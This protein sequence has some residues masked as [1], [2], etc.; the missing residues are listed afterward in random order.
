M[1][2]L[3]STGLTQSY[4]LYRPLTGSFTAGTWYDLD[5][6]RTT[7][8]SGIY[9]IKAFVWIKAIIRIIVSY[10]TIKEKEVDRVMKYPLSPMVR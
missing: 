1:T 5:V 9:M 8:D 3:T 4:M 6:D 7:L 10:D 2:G